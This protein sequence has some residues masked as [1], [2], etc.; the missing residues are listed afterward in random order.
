VHHFR[1]QDGYRYLDLP[2]SKAVVNHYKYQAW[3]TFKAKFFRRVSTY[4]TNWQDDQN[5]G[6]K[7]RAPGLGTEAIEPH[8]WRLQ[9]CEVWD[10][11]L[12]DFVMANFADSASGF[13]PWERSLA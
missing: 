2:E 5:K 1:L 8:N 12:K 11:G 6:S 4:V 10:T 3:D 9:F 7:D 13:L